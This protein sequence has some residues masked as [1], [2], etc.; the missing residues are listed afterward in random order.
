MTTILFIMC[1]IQEWRPHEDS[2]K[3]GIFDRGI[4]LD[5]HHVYSSFFTPYIK[6][7][8]M[9]DDRYGDEGTEE[10]ICTDCKNETNIYDCFIH[11]DEYFCVECCP[12]NYGE[13]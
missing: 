12:E 6:G 2:F 5:C 11:H 8:V 3:V 7:D 10:R 9:T 1:L 4:I 13:G